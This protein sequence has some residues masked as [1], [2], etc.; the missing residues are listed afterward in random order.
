LYKDSLQN[1]AWLLRKIV[2]E[3]ILYYELTKLGIKVERQIIMPISWDDLDLPKAFKLDLLVD[4]K[5]ILELKSVFPLPI[6]YFKQIKSHLSLM[7]LKHVL[8]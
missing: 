3:E 8:F 6:V 1:W 5:L 4:D 2:Y 7:N